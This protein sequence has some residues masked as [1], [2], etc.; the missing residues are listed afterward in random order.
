MKKLDATEIL[1]RAKKL[2]EEIKQKELNYIKQK[3]K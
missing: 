2:P 3:Y 1:A